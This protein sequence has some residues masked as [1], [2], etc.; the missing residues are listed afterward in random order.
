MKEKYI[1]MASQVTVI[2]RQ[3]TA[4]AEVKDP[5]PVTLF[6]VKIIQEPR[7]IGIGTHQAVPLW[8]AGEGKSKC[9]DQVCQGASEAIVIIWK[10]I[11]QKTLRP[12]VIMEERGQIQVPFTLIATPH[13]MNISKNKDIVTLNNNLKTIQN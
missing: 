6:I 4:E 7:I 13:S 2:G 5:F 1:I 9:Q 12:E 11:R 3:V 8:V 10:I